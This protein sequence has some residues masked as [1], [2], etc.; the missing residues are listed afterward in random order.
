MAQVQEAVAPSA[1]PPHEE[2][3]NMGPPEPLVVEYD[4]N[5]GVPAEY[6][7]FLPPDSMEYKMWVAAQ[8]GPEALAKLT[9]K[10][11]DGNE[12][13]KRL[14]GGKVKKKKKPE[15]VIETATRA[16]KK[17]VTTVMG[18][19]AFGIKLGE[20]AKAFGKKFASGSSVVKNASGG[21]QVD[22]QGDVLDDLPDF[23]VHKFASKGLKRDTI[24]VVVGKKK[25][26]YYDDD[27]DDDFDDE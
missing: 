8:E 18:L 5:T 15:V 4:P 12:I 2:E 10:D 9:L 7:E 1:D 16:R 3:A 27:E 26:K 6:N 14:P 25:Q 24:Y 13:E 23:L 19:D 20:A 21:E 11:E 22:I 17:S